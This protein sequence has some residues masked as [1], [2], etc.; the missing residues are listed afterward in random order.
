VTTWAKGEV[1]EFRDG[2]KREVTQFRSGYE[3]VRDFFKR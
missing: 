1:Q 2:V 3:R